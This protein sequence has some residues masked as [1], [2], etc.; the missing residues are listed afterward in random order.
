MFVKVTSYF[1]LALIMATSIVY[2]IFG[3][4][5]AKINFQPSFVNVPVFIGEWL[6]FFC[7]CVIAV[8]FLIEPARLQ[9]WHWGV[10]VYFVWVIAKTLEGYM[11][12]GGY[13]LRNA[14]MFYYP[15]LVII[16]SHFMGK[17]GL[18]FN[19]WLSLAGAIGFLLIVFFSPNILFVIAAMCCSLSIP[20][21]W[22]R[23][24]FMLVT[25]GVFLYV[26]GLISGG[27]GCLVGAV[28]V[29]LFLAWFAARLAG[30]RTRK[31]ILA[32]AG[33]LLV[34]SSF[35]WVWGDRVAGLSILQSMDVIEQ[36]RQNDVFVQ[37]TKKDFVQLK[38]KSQIYHQIESE[39]EPV[40]IRSE[41][42]S[43]EL[44]PEVKIS[45]VQP[46]VRSP[47]NTFYAAGVNALVEPENQSSSALKSGVLLTSK[48]KSSV[49]LPEDKNDPEVIDNLPGKV[50]TVVDVDVV[51]S[52]D[53]AGRV[54]TSQ[55]PLKR[56]YRLLATAN[57]NSA[58]RLFVWRDMISEFLSQ[59]PLFGFS[60]GWPQRSLSIEILRWAE[61]EWSRDGWIMPHNSFLHFIYR[62]GIVGLVFIGFIIFGLI[63]MTRIFLKA[64]SK[65]GALLVCLLIYWVAIAQFG[66]VFEFP[67][68]AI[69]FWTV[70][71]IALEYCRRLK[72]S[73]VV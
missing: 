29:I 73:T 1:C 38:L 6:I 37:G 13:A 67:Y 10:F 3:S 16:V 19:R 55:Q 62:G 18:N 72:E 35:L 40:E 34:I 20:R 25:A 68:Q 22:I 28:S 63:Y 12:D 9:P 41:A 69:P 23:G 5:V 42:K 30:F 27:R 4:V 64:H 14:A 60:F 70:F 31:Q 32:L 47:D 58:F 17:L 51:P 24:V 66:V 71:G 48:S 45:V 21:G 44:D 54:L 8:H 33:V 26:F 53:T 50:S 11:M 49:I 15:V 7:L 59:R 46:E 57:G 52:A 43:L 36:F 65:K 61:S 2:L 39:T 56:Q